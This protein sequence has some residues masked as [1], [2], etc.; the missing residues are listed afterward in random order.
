MQWKK[1]H[2]L[3]IVKITW[4]SIFQLIFIF[5][6]LNKKIPANPKYE[7]IEATVDSGTV[8]SFH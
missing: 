8:D 1:K 4:Q 5:Q 6:I 2:G 3:V 7:H